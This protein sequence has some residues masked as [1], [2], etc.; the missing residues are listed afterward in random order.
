MQDAGGYAFV[1]HRGAEVIHL[2]HVPDLDPS[3]NPSGCYVHVGEVDRL[4]G[5]FLDAG[6]AVSEIRDEPWGMREFRL[7]DPSG[8]LVAWVA[9][10]PAEPTQ[11]ADRHGA[12]GGRSPLLPAAE[13]SG[14][15]A[16]LPQRLVEHRRR[17]DSP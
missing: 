12:D 6:V 2:C 11:R 10:P 5:E 15:G 13:L 1:R 16:A 9:S 17:P 3:T 7:T 4:R 14:S 8:N